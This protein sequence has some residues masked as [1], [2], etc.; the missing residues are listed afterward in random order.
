MPEVSSTDAAQIVG[1]GEVT[2]R[3]HVYNGRLSA[4][5]IGVRKIIRIELDNLQK[6]ADEYQYRFDDELAQKLAK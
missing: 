1:I 6:L 3:R 4:R 2:I 5:R